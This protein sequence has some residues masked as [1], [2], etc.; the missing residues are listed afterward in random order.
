LH[1][2]SVFFMGSYKRPREL[3]WVSGFLLIKIGVVV[4]L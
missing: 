2:L 3:T 1:M 4:L